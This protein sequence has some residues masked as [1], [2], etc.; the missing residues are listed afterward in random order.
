MTHN[1][2]ITQY[3]SSLAHSP[4]ILSMMFSTFF[5]LWSFYEVKFLWRHD[6]IGTGLNNVFIWSTCMLCMWWLLSSTRSFA[7]KYGQYNCRFFFNWIE[8]CANVLWLEKQFA[9]MMQGM[10]DSPS[11]TLRHWRSTL[12]EQLSS[13]ILYMPGASSTNEIV[14]VKK[15][16]GN[17]ITRNCV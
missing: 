3:A 16:K 12:E 4:V 14:L 11:W 2:Y 1:I 6:K 5:T 7:W 15:F 10:I 9:K 17:I 13:W 8:V